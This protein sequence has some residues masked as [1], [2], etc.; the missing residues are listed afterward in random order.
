VGLFVIA[1]IGFL[2]TILFDELERRVIPWK[3][4]K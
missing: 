1:L 4:N 2:I 3:T